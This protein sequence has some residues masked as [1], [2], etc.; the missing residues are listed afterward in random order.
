MRAYM[1]WAIRDDLNPELGGELMLPNHPE[2]IADLT[3]PKWKVRSNGDI[4]IEEKDEIK[5]R[6]GRS[7]DYGDALSFTKF[8]TP[9]RP[10]A[11]LI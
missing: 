6:L 3:E 10:R 4:I 7:P 8:P 9:Q 1:Y 2:L 11:R 5:K